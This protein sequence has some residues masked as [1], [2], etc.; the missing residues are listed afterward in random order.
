MDL[1]G[2]EDMRAYDGHDRV[3]QPGALSDPS[4][5]VERSSSKPSRA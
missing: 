4:H 2:G 5:K 1:L 3:Q